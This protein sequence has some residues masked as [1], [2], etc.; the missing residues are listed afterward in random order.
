MTP[1]STRE[2]YWGSRA[3][4]C[5]AM[6]RRS[7]AVRTSATSAAMSA[8]VPRRSIT[9]LVQAAQCFGG[10]GSPGLWVSVYRHRTRVSASRALRSRAVRG[11]PG[12]VPQVSAMIRAGNTCVSA[13]RARGLAFSG[14]AWA[15]GMEGQ[16]GRRPATNGDSRVKVLRA[17]VSTKAQARTSWRACPR[18]TP[19][20]PRALLAWYRPRARALRIRSTRDPWAILVAEVM[21]QQT[22]IARVDEAWVHFMRRFPTPRRLARSSQ[23]DVLRAWAGLGYNK[24]ALALWRAAGIIETE[25]AGQV[26]RE[27]ADLE[28]LPGV[29]P[30]TARAVASVA[31]GQPVAAVDT[32]V[33]RVLCAYRRCRDAKHAPPGRGRWARGR[34]RSGRVDAGLD[35]ARRH[36]VPGPP[37]TL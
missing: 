13:A 19:S 5:D 15:Y 28:S 30:Y 17:P 9:A 20:I 25:H 11:V 7:E 31:Y 29:G 1:A 23:A 2:M 21:S 12:Q 22:Q 33:R 35:R 8:G 34:N 14:T 3:V 16:C 27:L 37:S 10:D 24:R 4:P 18:G 26:P 32:N 6:P 36:G